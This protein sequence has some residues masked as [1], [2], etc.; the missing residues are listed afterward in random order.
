M[1]KRNLKIV[2]IDRHK[3]KNAKLALMFHFKDI[4][5]K[6]K[7]DIDFANLQRKQAP[8]IQCRMCGIEIKA[9]QI[10]KHN[11]L[12]LQR[13]ET[14]KKTSKIDKRFIEI[15]NKISHEISGMT[16]SRVSSA[17]I[18][19]R[20]LNPLNTP[21]RQL[22]INSPLITNHGL[23][24]LSEIANKK[25]DPNKMSTPSMPS[26][27]VPMDLGGS[28]FQ[29]NRIIRKDAPPGKPKLQK[30]ENKP[31]LPLALKNEPEKKESDVK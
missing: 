21:K 8:E 25:Q 18:S 13:I 1:K 12:C 16:K 20:S 9:S 3:S 15:S 31:P 17:I 24:T 5:R 26:R 30:A 10:E 4:C 28:S 22:P 14:K 27:P 6:W 7:D 19:K 29:M 11:D 2:N 23:N